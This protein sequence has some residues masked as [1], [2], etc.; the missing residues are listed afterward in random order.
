MG[1]SPPPGMAA[2]CNEAPEAAWLAEYAWDARVLERMMFECARRDAEAVAM[3]KGPH[4]GRCIIE[5]AW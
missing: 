2:L 1:L 3:H 5:Q 4:I